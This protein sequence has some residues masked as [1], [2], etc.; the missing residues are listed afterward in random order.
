MTP[1]ERARCTAQKPVEQ[2]V[3]GVA[4]EEGSSATGA[5]PWMVRAKGLV[6]V[7]GSAWKWLLLLVLVLGFYVEHR[8]QTAL[9]A[10]L[11]E[12]LT[13]EDT[14]VLPEH[15]SVS[16]KLDRINENLDKANEN[17]EDIWDEMTALER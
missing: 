1:E 15:A 2:P 7:A 9:R 13:A 8:D 16:V 4:V 10:Q 17:L 12:A 11:A 3:D 14:F 5:V 6:R